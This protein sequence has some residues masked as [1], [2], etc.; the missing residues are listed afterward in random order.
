MVRLAC[1]LTKLINLA[2]PVEIPIFASKSFY[3]TSLCA[4]NKKYGGMRP[5][6]IGKTLRRLA[7][8]VGCVPIA[9]RLGSHFRRVP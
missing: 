6:A 1:V 2:L 8:K 9:D 4:L 3:G 7:K 5:I